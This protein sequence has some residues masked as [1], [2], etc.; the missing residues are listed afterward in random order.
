MTTTHEP[1]TADTITTTQI[2]Q[3]RDEA[4]AAGDDRQVEYCDV[5][6][7]RW[8]TPARRSVARQVCADAISSA[9]AMS[10]SQAI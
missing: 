6:L 9:H 1:I 10:D 7:A 8:E 2:R 4:V 3:L 5:A